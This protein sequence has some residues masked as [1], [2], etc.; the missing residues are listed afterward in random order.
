MKTLAK[1]V[2]LF[3]SLWS[4]PLG[5]SAQFAFTTNDGTITITKYT[6]SDGYV[7]IPN[8]ING[9]PVTSIAHDAFS[10]QYNLTN[11]IIPDSITNIEWFAFWS[12]P[13]LYSVTIPKY[14]A[15]IGGSAFGAFGGGSGGSGIKIFFRGDKPL[16]EF[17][18]LSIGTMYYLPGTLGWDGTDAVLWNPQVQTD[19]SSFG[20]RT[21]QFGFNIIG[22]ADVPIVV[23]S[24]TDLSSSVWVQLESVNLTNGL[25]YFSDPDWSNY[26]SRFY[27]IR[28]P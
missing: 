13:D 15:S 9:W 5:V 21:N 25:F 4:A 27:R 8:M 18:V 28:S 3:I 22:T 7:V 10:Y 14:V 11:V 6:N 12:C 26:P 17:S 19:D 24:C 2:L 23:D 16:M 20:L 1:T